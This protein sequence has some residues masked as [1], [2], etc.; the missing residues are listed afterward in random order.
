[1]HHLQE[2][3]HASQWHPVAIRV[4][5]GSLR[6]SPRG[7]KELHQSSSKWSLFLRVSSPNNLVRIVIF[8]SVPLCKVIIGYLTARVQRYRSGRW[9]R[10]KRR[11]VLRKCRSFNGRSSRQPRYGSE[12]AGTYVRMW[13]GSVESWLKLLHVFSLKKGSALSLVWVYYWKLIFSR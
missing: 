13:S 6:E 5:E 3:S 12:P 2:Q 11:D 9:A 10:S 1:M 8:L 4:R 7:F